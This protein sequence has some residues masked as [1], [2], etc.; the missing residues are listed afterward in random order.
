M[1][2]LRKLMLEELELRD[3]RCVANI[4]RLTR[5]TSMKNPSFPRARVSGRYPVSP[6]GS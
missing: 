6:L 5:S 3:F 1:T 4:G 2:Q